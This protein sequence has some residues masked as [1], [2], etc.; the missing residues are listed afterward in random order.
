MLYIHHR[1]KYLK[2]QNLPFPF[3]CCFQSL[4]RTTRFARRRV[5]RCVVA[6]LGLWSNFVECSDF[7][8]TDD[9][10]LSNI[11]IYMQVVLIG[12]LGQRLPT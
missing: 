8:S 1:K 3:C 12:N 11:A 5:I 10:M 4:L 6:S 2:L 9:L 7:C